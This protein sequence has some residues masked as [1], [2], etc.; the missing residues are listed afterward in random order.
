MFYLFI[1]ILMLLDEAD[2]I[3]LRAYAFTAKV[4]QLS[5]SEPLTQQGC[6][7]PSMDSL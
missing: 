3:F 5:H 7:C 6:Q 4:S 1:H 2:L